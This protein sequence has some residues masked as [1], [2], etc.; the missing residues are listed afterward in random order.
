VESL[1]AQLRSAS[2]RHESALLA[3]G[4]LSGSAG[5][6]GTS[7]SA[8]PTPAAPSASPN[9]PSAR[10]E[11]ASLVQEA[12]AGGSIEDLDGRLHQGDAGAQLEVIVAAVATLQASS[13]ATAAS[14]LVTVDAVRR[15]AEAAAAAVGNASSQQHAS[16]M[17]ALRNLTGRTEAADR[18]V[19]S[20]AAAVNESARAATQAVHR[21]VD[22]FASASRLEASRIAADLGAV[23][24]TLTAAVV[25]A[26]SLAMQSLRVPGPRGPP[27]INGSCVR[28][29]TGETTLCPLAAPAGCRDERG[30]SVDW[31]AVLKRNNAF[32]YSYMGPGDA[33]FVRS[34]HSLSDGTRGAVSHTLRQVYGRGAGVSR[35]LYSD[36]LPWAR[37][38]R[39]LRTPRVSSSMLRPPRIAICRRV[40][41][42]RRGRRRAGCPADGMDGPPGA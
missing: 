7:P 17:A 42:P 35:F 16:A 34:Q 31:F 21:R 3:A 22:G 24:E 18:E 33:S 23:N 29:D 39:A 41:P 9:S 13:N 11:V 37:S 27:G 5:S 1:G 2:Q 28:Y 10:A 32:D 15:Q 20:R 19:R 4:L 14:L 12:R 8:T 25:R 38:R 40:M 30:A 6:V 36:Q 26:Q